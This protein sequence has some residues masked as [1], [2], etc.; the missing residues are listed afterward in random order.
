[1]VTKLTT[2]SRSND[3]KQT[4]VTVGAWIF[5]YTGQGGGHKA[6][7]ESLFNDSACYQHPYTPLNI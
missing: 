6:V 7:S 5:E 4:S 2:A 1:M 3:K